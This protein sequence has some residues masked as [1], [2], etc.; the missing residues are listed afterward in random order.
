[1]GLPSDRR[2]PFETKSG[3]PGSGP[4]VRKSGPVVRPVELRHAFKVRPR[5]P[6]QHWHPPDA[7][8][9]ATRAALLANPKRNKRAIRRE[10]QGADRWIDEFLR[11]PVRQVVELP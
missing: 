1:M 11:A 7:D 8:V 5:L 3:P 4:V 6:A 2:S 10:P 9:A